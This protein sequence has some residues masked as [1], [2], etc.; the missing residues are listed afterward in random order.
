MYGVEIVD[1]CL[2]LELGWYVVD[3]V[4]SEGLLVVVVV[5]VDCLLIFMSSCD[6]WVVVVLY[7]GW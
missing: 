7:G 6:G 3:G 4:F 1:V 2:L 5:I